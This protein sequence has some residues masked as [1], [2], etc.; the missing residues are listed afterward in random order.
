MAQ[1]FLPYQDVRTM[2]EKVKTRKD[3][4]NNAASSLVYNKPIDKSKNTDLNITFAN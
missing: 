4:V 3:Y 2:D 1:G